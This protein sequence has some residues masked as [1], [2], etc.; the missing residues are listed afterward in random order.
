[1]SLPTW[2]FFVMCAGGCCI[3]GGYWMGRQRLARALRRAVLDSASEFYIPCETC[4]GTGR[5]G[6]S[7]CE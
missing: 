2:L 3:W 6:P 1:M 4:K 7:Q 5:K